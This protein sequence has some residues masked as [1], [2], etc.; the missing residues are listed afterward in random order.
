MVAALALDLARTTIA[1]IRSHCCTSARDHARA[2]FS[3]FS[4]AAIRLCRH[5]LQIVT[6]EMTHAKQWH[7]LK[8]R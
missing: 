3:S 8:M 6:A 4:G 7:L 5:Q 1:Y 2:T